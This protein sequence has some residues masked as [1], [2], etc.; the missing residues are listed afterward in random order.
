[1][2]IIISRFYVV[3]AIAD[4]KNMIWSGQTRGVQLGLPLVFC[5]VLYI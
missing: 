2:I 4:V 1:M 5:Y 3:Q